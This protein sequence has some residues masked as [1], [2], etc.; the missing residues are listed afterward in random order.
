MSRSFARFLSSLMLSKSRRR[1]VL[2]LLVLV[3]TLVL[4]SNSQRAPTALQRHLCVLDSGSSGLGQADSPAQPPRFV[5]MSTG[6]DAPSRWVT[7]G[8]LGSIVWLLLLTALVLA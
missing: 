2:L 1:M 5:P 7:W 8:S 3:C 6:Q 4:A